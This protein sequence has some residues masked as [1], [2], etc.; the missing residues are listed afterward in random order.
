MFTRAL[1][2]PP[3]PER[4]G[5]HRRWRGLPQAAQALALAE[6]ALAHP[7]LSVAIVSSN[8][9]GAQLARELRFFLGADAELDI[10]VFPDTET[11]PYDI[12]SPSPDIV[13]QR[14]GALYRLGFSSRGIVVASLPNLLRRLPPVDYLDSRCLAFDIGQ[15]CDPIALRD[16]LE[17]GG[18]QRADTV[19]SP[20]EFALRGGLIDLFPVGAALPCRV[21]LLGERVDSLREFD[22]D[23]QRTVSRIERLR[24]LPTLEYPL[25]ADA[26]RRFRDNWHRRF[27][28]DPRHC[29]SYRDISDGRPSPGAEC[30]LP[31]FFESTAQWFDYLPERSWLF[32][33][34]E[35][36]EPACERLWREVVERRNRH[37]SLAR[38]LLGA[39]ELFLAPDAVFAE[40]G[41]RAT[42]RCDGAPGAARRRAGDLGVAPAPEL[43]VDHAG[44]RPLE[45]L[46]RFARRRG[47]ATLL[48][49]ASSGREQALRD[50]LERHGLGAERCDGWADF[51]RRRR[52]VFTAVSPLERG[53]LLPDGRSVLTETELFDRPVAPALARPAGAHA[54]AVIKSLAEIRPGAPVVHIEHGVGRYL[55]LRTLSSGGVEDEYLCV[56]YAEQVKLLVPVSSINL[57]TRY[58]GPDDAEAPLHRLG[59]AQW[60]RSRR[61]VAD[62]VRDL[63]ARL[64]RLHAERF[65][66]DGIA[67]QLPDGYARFAAEC[68]FALTADQ[69][70]AVDSVIAD[71]RRPAP[72]DRLVC[73]DVGFGKTEV[74]MRAAYIAVANGLQV[75]VLAP[76]TLLAQQHCESFRD[77]FSGHAA[78]VAALSRF[79]GKSQ[80]RD[81]A[82]AISNGELDIV[83]GTQRLL[84]PDI[85]FAALGLVVIDEEHRFG[86]RAKAQ[87]RAMRSRA[88]SLSLTATPIP[89]SL[90]NAL[91]GL[92]ELSIIA[93]PPPGRMPIKTFVAEFDEDLVR[94]ALQREILRGGQAYYLHNDVRSIHRRA[95]EIEKLAPENRVG[96][97][98]GQMGSR[99]LAQAMD[100]FCRQRTDVLVCSAIIE[101]GIDVTNA[102]TIV[103]DRADK[104]GLAQL[105]QLRG[106]VGR[107]NRQ[108]Y[109]WLL[110]PPAGAISRDAKH[111]LHAVAQTTDLGIGFHLACHDMEIRGA[112][113]LLGEEQSGQIHEI[114]FAA[115]TA[116]L[117][118]AVAAVRAGQLPSSED[119]LRAEQAIDLRVP[120]RIPD[121]YLPDVNARLILYQRINAA[122]DEPS[123]DAL[124]DEMIDRFGPLPA[125]AQRL[126]DVA[127]LKLA[128]A[129]L[130]LERIDANAEGGVLHFGADTPLEPA[131]ALALVRQQPDRYRMPDG[132][133]LALRAGMADPDERLARMRALVDALVERLDAGARRRDGHVHRAASAPAQAKR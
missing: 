83:I 36:I 81:I 111:R 88:D 48:C 45:A 89:R 95:L 49:A 128:A 85:R 74:A 42:V 6:A 9:R 121:D 50:L 10:L 96:V 13:S 47:A 113:N 40:L 62:S 28:A 5:D 125:S 123:L 38:P 8:R 24:A 71:L 102:N 107:G 12:F 37:D 41:K 133:R 93:T 18:Y 35:P 67:C 110:V 70:A 122:G 82:A 76:T 44:T 69:Q 11:L 51:A 59:S 14:F 68:P 75:A 57:I 53:A 131:A 130:R 103:I 33:A 109:A 73:G 39:E 114:G 117:K 65:A 30:Y 23:S 61:K 120:L 91:D 43:R 118:R 87:L 94:E 34:D 108:A 60:R 119:M 77:R 106:R 116:M 27:D 126:L 64:L 46:E 127:K 32:V 21:D 72:M 129:P 3:L 63:A 132:L 55:G 78:R 17:R 7:G 15:D 124:R 101:S 54:G 16:R 4:P 56:E 79:R 115:Y 99:A 19:R 97:A 66:C 84:G 86:V 92:T 29:R 98:H 26:V 52:G 31:L 22:P 105:H 112:G 80:Q 58:N 90:R 100:D 1:A 20:G 25:D 104:L 2:P